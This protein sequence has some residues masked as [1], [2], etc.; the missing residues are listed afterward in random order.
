MI[1]VTEMTEEDTME[2]VSSLFE[3]E[4]E[5]VCSL[6]WELLKE[7][8]SAFFVADEEE[9]DYFEQ[10]VNRRVYDMVLIYEFRFVNEAGRIMHCQIEPNMMEAMGIDE[11][12]LYKAALSNLR[13]DTFSILNMSEDIGHSVVDE[14]GE[15]PVLVLTNI[16]RRDGSNV[17]LDNQFMESVCAL[18]H[19]NF[20][21]VPA[22]SHEWIVIKKKAGK[23]FTRDQINEITDIVKAGNV[24]QAPVLSEHIFEYDKMTHSILVAKEYENAA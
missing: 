21:L 12:E 23:N 22:C 10:V 19:D 16:N 2:N 24:P 8:V 14:D 7:N 13:Y 18:F 20:Y 4:Q 15:L 11:N 5:M 3:K 1:F 9:S 6:D 17:I